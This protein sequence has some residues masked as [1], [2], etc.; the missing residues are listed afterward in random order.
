MQR[1]DLILFSEVLYYLSRADIAR[2]A[3]RARQSIVPAGAMLLVHYILPTDYPC[4]GDE[5][6]AVLHP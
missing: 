6:S 3:R 5:A 1:F 2:T 4:S